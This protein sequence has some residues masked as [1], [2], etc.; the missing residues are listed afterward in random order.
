MHIA[1]FVSN[2]SGSYLIPINCQ[3]ASTLCVVYVVVYVCSYAVSACVLS[4]CQWAS[5]KTFLST[6]AAPPP[7]PPRDVSSDLRHILTDTGDSEHSASSGRD[8]WGMKISFPTQN[9]LNVSK[10]LLNFSVLQCNDPKHRQKSLK[11]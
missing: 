8:K 5:F 2:F 11:V 9:F 6:P 3:S 10:I 1:A 4:I 7:A